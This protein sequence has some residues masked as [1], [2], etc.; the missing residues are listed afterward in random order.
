[1]IHRQSNAPAIRSLILLTLALWLCGCVALKAEEAPAKTTEAEEAAA[2]DEAE[3]NMSESE[4]IR[5][6]KSISGKLSLGAIGGDVSEDVIGT[7]TAA[8]GKVY[9]LKP[10][11]ETITKTLEKFNNSTVTLTGKLR[12]KE[13]YLIVSGAS[14]PSGG[15][16][17]DRRKRGGI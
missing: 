4:I 16:A 11:N 3:K 12:N 17:P 9:L 8:G 6:V 1:M 7:L 5:A 15:A 10:G 13:K 14:E 2:E